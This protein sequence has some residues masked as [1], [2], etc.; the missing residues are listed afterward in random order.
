[1]SAGERAIAKEMRREEK[2]RKKRIRLANKMLIPASKKTLESMHLNSFDPSG[3]FYLDD[4]R[5][6]KV[7]LVEGEIGKL[8][9][10]CKSL[11]GR[12]RITL[13][14][15]EE[16]DRA[17]CH[18][19]LMET[20]EIYEEVRQLILSDESELQKAV[21]LKAL[22]VDDAMNLIAV[23]AFKDIRFSYASY[24]RGNKDWKKECLLEVSEEAQ[25]FKSAGLYGK[26]F[27]ILSF[28]KNSNKEIIRQFEKLG[29]LMHIAMDLN[30]LT[31]EERFDFKRA[32]EKKYNRRLMQEEEDYINLS[33]SMVVFG[34]S[35]DAVEIVEETIISFLLGQGFLVVPAFHNHGAVAQ[36]VIS[37]GLLDQCIM[38]NVRSNL[39]KEIVGGESHAD[40]K[41]EV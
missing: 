11:K 19:S 24:V 20:G 32:I 16:S 5:W 26:S 29:C 25:F 36:S 8:S 2:E 41:V 21:T 37:L 27:R 30:S 3:T 7:Y 14:I 33:I 10:V 22:S 15:G 28:P 4:D 1:M 39:F 17:T 6:L 13:H 40:A 31:E 12:I 9:D 18:L 34:D 23:N 38:R 35:L